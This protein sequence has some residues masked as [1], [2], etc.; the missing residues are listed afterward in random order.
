MRGELSKSGKNGQDTDF[1]N[2]SIAQLFLQ[3]AVYIGYWVDG[4]QAA[5]R[6]MG[7]SFA[8]S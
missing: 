4:T 6:P 2:L 7:H 3:P 5:H 8:Y 1:Q